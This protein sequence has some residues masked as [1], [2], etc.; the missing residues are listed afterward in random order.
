MHCLQPILGAYLKRAYV[1]YGREE[2]VNG[3][4]GFGWV[5]KSVVKFCSITKIF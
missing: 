3:S 1:D 5:E 4:W 2:R